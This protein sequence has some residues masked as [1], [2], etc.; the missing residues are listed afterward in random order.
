MSGHTGPV[1]FGSRDG[2]GVFHRHRNVPFDRRLGGRRPWRLLAGFVAAVAAVLIAPLAW[3]VSPAHAQPTPQEIEAE[4]DQA[5]RQ[6]APIIE[7][8]N[9]TREELK[10]LRR[11]A[12]RLAEKI[13]PLQLKVDLAM[14]EV[15]E[16]TVI[17]YKSGGNISPF[18]ALLT[19]DSPYMLTGRMALLDQVAQA[20]QRQVAKLVETK[21]EYEAEKAELDRLVQELAER[22]AE[23][24]ARAAEIDAEIERLQALRIRAYGT[25]NATGNLRPAACPAEYDGGPGSKAAQFACEQIGKPYVW[26]SAGPDS[27]DCSGLTMAAWGQAGVSL[28]HNAA[29]QRNVTRYVN[30]SELRPGDLVF[31]YGDLSHVAIYVGGGWIVDASQPGVPVKMRS[32]DAPGPIHSYGRP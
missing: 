27:Y 25:T 8:H 26:G 12:D 21:E 5:W 1:R 31:Y 20:R 16:M 24:Q 17:A 28:P 3:P 2:H 23:L 29:Q 11:K 14:A 7:Q 13:V 10:D 6:L 18:H 22:E 4:I 15:S 9:A 19:S 30:R 32:I